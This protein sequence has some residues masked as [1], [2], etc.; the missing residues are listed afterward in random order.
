MSVSFYHRPNDDDDGGDDDCDDVSLMMHP[1]LV[2]LCQWHH[3]PV[4]IVNKIK[5]EREKKI[6]NKNATVLNG[7]FFIS[8]K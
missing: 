8:V 7:N 4:V 2:Q 3:Q 6:I 1:L 5:R